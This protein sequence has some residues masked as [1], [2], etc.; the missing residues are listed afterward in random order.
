MA[1]PALRAAEK[2]RAVRGEA[3]LFLLFVGPNLF[4]FA[5]F[6]FW[7]IIY[8]AYL[9]TRRWDMIAPVKLYV[10]LDNFRDL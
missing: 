4:F 8:S 10:G 3:L 1:T 2:R 5:V 7:P 6:S 9:S